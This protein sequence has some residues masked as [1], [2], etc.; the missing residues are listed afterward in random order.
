MDLRPPI[1][2]GRLRRFV[3]LVAGRVAQLQLTQTAASLAFLSVLAMVPVFS[4]AI[5][6]LGASPVFAQPRDAL[7][8]FLSAT[9]FLPGFS[10]L[11]VRYLNQFAA[12]AGHLSLIGGLVFFATAFTALLTVDK[13]LNRIWQVRRP[14]PLVRRLTLYWTFLTLGPLLLA[15]TLVANGLLLAQLF[16]K[17]SQLAVQRA[18]LSSLPWIA[19]IMVLTLLYRLVPNAPV[20][21]R[22][23]LLGGLLGA[24][25]LEA[26]KQALAFQAVK[27]PTYTVVY[28]AFAALPLILLW[29]LSVW[30]AVLAAAVVVACLPAWSSGVLPP[31]AYGPAARYARGRGVLMAL[32]AANRRGEAA[33]QAGSLR[34]L[35]DQ[36]A[37]AADETA[38]LLAGLGYLRRHWL[39]GRDGADGDPMADE[40]VWQEWWL[41]SPQAGALSLRDLFEDC[42]QGEAP[43]R[44]AAGSPSARPA[45]LALAELDVRLDA[46]PG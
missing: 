9:M 36:D 21:W 24:A 17:A 46:L 5:S 2:A 39:L 45:P 15:L 38:A 29:L 43:G 20:R 27:L 26:L 40:A 19:S 12:K 23:A 28:G 10:E 34:A 18:W 11:V 32:L 8:Q 42:W 44:A 37:E 6:L 22:D 31:A 16:E 30:L 35:F 3:A 1:P 13:T 25:A 14:R 7:L 41:L 4:I 33:V